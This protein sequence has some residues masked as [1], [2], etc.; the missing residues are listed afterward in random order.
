MCCRIRCRWERGG[1][2]VQLAYSRPRVRPSGAR[3]YGPPRG[4]SALFSPMRHGGELFGVTGLSGTKGDES[5]ALGNQTIA[6]VHRED[7][8][9]RYSWFQALCTEASL[10]MAHVSHVGVQSFYILYSH[11]FL[12][13]WCLLWISL[14]LDAIY[15]SYVSLIPIFHFFFIQSRIYTCMY[16]SRVLFM[17]LYIHSAYSS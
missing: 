2:D 13:R 16:I 5:L 14:Q 9:C 11:S 8:E 15:T 17:K 12:R 10:G 3:A 7:F 4:S 1:P 6:Q